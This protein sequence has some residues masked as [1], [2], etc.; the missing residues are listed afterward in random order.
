MADDKSSMK[1]LKAYEKIRDM[2]LS[3][4]SFRG[5]V[6]SCLNLKNCQAQWHHEA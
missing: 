6:L 1:S 2:I 4:L 3:G 5:P